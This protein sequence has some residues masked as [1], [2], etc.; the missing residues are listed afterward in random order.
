MRSYFLQE[1]KAANVN[2]DL[3]DVEEDENARTVSGGT[4]GGAD[5]QWS[6]VE[7]SR[8]SV[9]RGTIR[10]AFVVTFCLRYSYFA[11]PESEKKAFRPRYT[12]HR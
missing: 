10:L 8:V 2:G 7:D 6:T 1:S 12:Y 5:L 9:I 4:R 3:M 11:S